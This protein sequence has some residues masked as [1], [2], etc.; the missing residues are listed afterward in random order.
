MRTS[1]P[2]PIRRL[3]PALLSSALVACGRSDDDS[4]FVVRAGA[5]PAVSG[6]GIVVAGDWV[7]YFANEALDGPTGAN[8]N[9]DPDRI[10][11]VAF[12]VNSAT[13]SETNLEVAGT[14][15]AIV[16]DEVYLV[17][18]E[19]A[20]GRDWD[21]DGFN[22]DRVL[23]HWSRATLTGPTFVDLLDS[24]G[25]PVA[26]PL[27]PEGRL[28]Y[29]AAGAPLGAADETFLRVLDEGQPTVPQAVPAPAGGFPRGSPAPVV[30]PLRAESGLLLCTLDETEDGGDYNGDMDPDDEHVLVLLDVLFDSTLPPSALVST[31]LAMADEDEPIAVRMLGSHAWRVAFLVDELEQGGTNLNDAALFAPDALVPQNCAGVS[32]MDALDRVLH[33]VDYRPLALP[34][35]PSSPV[36]TGLAGHDRVLLLDDFVATISAE[37]EVDCNLN[38]GTVVT[39]TDL[40][41]DVLRW[42]RTMPGAIPEKDADLLH[43]LATLTAG[44]SFG[45]AVL[46]DRF[47]AVIDEA[48]DSRNLDM[49]AGN[50]ELVAWLDPDASNPTWDLTHQHPTNRA[51]GTG[52]FDSNDVSEP[53]AGTSWMAGEAVG[54]RLALV[55][56]EEV[57][58]TNPNV[59]SINTNLDCDFVPKDTDKV[60]GLPVWTDFESGPT[61]DFDGMGYAVD[62]MNAGIVIASGFAFFRVSEGDDNR[63]YDDDP[64][65]NVVLFRNPLTTCNPVFMGTASIVPG[66]VIHTDRGTSAAFLSTGIDFNG[67]G[68][69]HDEPVVRYF[70]F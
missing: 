15:A 19:G 44:G 51:F 52:I 14:G 64:A 42:V 67:D 1:T 43:A 61:L 48:A 8:L 2:P 13:G 59:G 12:A 41:D 20:D 36:N 53:F 29:A 57:P 28:F 24:E 49:K 55:F 62:K 54:E 22:D 4:S 47:V 17:V 23:L 7:V 56:L 10:D 9:L 26:V 70:R 38:Q 21:L 50:H 58:G 30:R 11:A 46:D 60:D 68:D 69:A 3:L 40:D 39:D 37:D 6:T 35:Q 66:P 5:H 31:E 34:P 25:A 65:D 45:V 63:D 16:G 18:S 32:D 27:E 33:W